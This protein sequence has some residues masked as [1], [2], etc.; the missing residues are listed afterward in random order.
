MASFRVTIACFWN[1]EIRT[2]GSK[3]MY[4]GGK[5]KLFAC[6]SNMGFNDFKRLVCSKIGIDPTRNVVKLSFK[7]RMSDEWVVFPVEDDDS[8]DAMWEHSKANSTPS[9]ELYVELL[10]RGNQALNVT[11]NPS[12]T[13]T[14]IPIVTQE[15]PNPSVPSPSSTPSDDPNVNLGES[16][17]LIPW[18][19]GNESN[20]LIDSPSE[21]DVDVDEE[22]IANNIIVPPTPYAV[23]HSVPALHT[24]SG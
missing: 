6:N 22:T 17:Q 20:E 21:D 18:V 14:P 15:T 3:V 4:L 16:S 9:V 23:W 11:S 12:P 8:I 24:G 13:P 1:G 19:D 5:S 10:R 7:Y 2:S